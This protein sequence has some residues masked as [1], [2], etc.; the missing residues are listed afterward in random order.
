[1][2]RQ[3]KASPTPLLRVLLTLVTFVLLYALTLAARNG[4]AD[5]YAQPASTFLQ[6]QRD[7][8]LEM[9]ETQWQ[10]VEANFHQ[11]LSLSPNNP[12]VLAELGRMHRIQLEPDDVDLVDV[13]KHGNLAIG[14][15][16]QAARL[17]PAWSWAWISLAQVRWELYQDNN[18]HY[19][20]ALIFAMYFAPWERDI[21]R[22]VVD[23]AL[24]TWESLS[25]D[26][27]VAVLGMIDRS[28][29]RTPE[30]LDA[31]LN[32]EWQFLCEAATDTTNSNSSSTHEL[33]RLQRHC[34]TLTFVNES[35]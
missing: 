15:Y 2:S 23:L 1:M 22:W 14:Y 32:T 16:T 11:S 33:S 9:T 26:A 12:D 30:V 19:H 17:R 4:L 21:Q 28:L 18:E 8:G 5:L 31:I 3:A 7:E 24:H 34:A 29:E 25:P 35:V 6:D 20:Q 13:E 10:A 27:T